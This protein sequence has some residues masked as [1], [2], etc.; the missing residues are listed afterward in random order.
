M[1]KE[2]SPALDLHQIP[3]TFKAWILATRPRT[4]SLSFVPL[5]TGLSL[6]YLH[7]KHLNWLLAISTLFCVPWIQIGMHLIDDAIDS[8]KGGAV[9]EKVGLKKAQFLS[10]EQLFFGGFICFAFTLFF[11]IPLILTGG[12]PFALLLLLSIACAYLYTGGPFPL[13]YLGISDAFILV[14]YGWVAT[15]ATYYLQT[16]KIDPGSLLAGTQIGC[17]AI[18]PHVINNLRDHVA[19]RLVEKK[20]LVVR[21]GP[22]FARCE[23]TLF[24]L[25]PFLLGLLWIEIES[26]W[27]ALLPFFALPPVVNNLKS[28]WQTEPSRAFHPFLVKSAL[29]QVLFGCLLV[30]GML[31]T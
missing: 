29:C 7:L 9:L 11:G 17:L 4:L 2:Q 23:I 12:W 31:L 5:V 8:K 10:T 20:T 14:F 18:V 1:S 26:V 15:A 24:S 30:I 25:F 28:I 21:L 13:S 6:A 3:S 16:G 19:D 27:M 22:F